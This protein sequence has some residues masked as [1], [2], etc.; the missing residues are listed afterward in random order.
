MGGEQ[1]RDLLLKLFDL[2]IERFD[3]RD[4][5]DGDPA[6]RGPFGSGQPRSCPIETLEQSLGALLASRLL[7]HSLPVRAGGGAA[8]HVEGMVY[9]PS[10]GPSVRD[11]E[12]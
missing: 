2:V 6:P 12:D 3:H 8:S 4:Q 1:L 9:S 10:W 5:P 7:K 11:R